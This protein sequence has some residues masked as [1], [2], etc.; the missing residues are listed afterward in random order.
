M[1]T[2]SSP[3]ATITR[4]T[5]FEDLPEYMTAEEIGVWLN[6]S[7]N[8]VYAF[9]RGLPRL[10]CGGRLIRVPKSALRVQEAR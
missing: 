3:V 4:Y 7:R 2:P 8:K 6:L 1:A 10:D 5:R 9:V